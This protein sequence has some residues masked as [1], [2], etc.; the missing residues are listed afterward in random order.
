M[1]S[2]TKKALG[3]SLIVL[4]ILVIAWYMELYAYFTLASLQNNR[5]YLEEAVKKNYMQAVALFIL[6]CVAVISLGM[7][8]VPPLTMVGGFLFGF[9]PAGIYVSI[10][11]T[12][13]TTISFLLIRYVLGNV[14][15]GKYAQ[16]LDRF[17]E[18]IAV[19]GAASYLLTMQLIGLIPYFIINILAALAHVSTFTF[20]WTTFVGSLPILFIY[21]FAGRQLALVESVGDIFSPS[22]IALL[23]VLV[24]VALIPIVLRFSRRVTDLE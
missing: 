11:A 2:G 4:I 1:N 8:G 23:V 9:I 18:K 16:K 20:I 19:H 7:P 13:G 24:L 5:V 10:S 15:R 6:V 17:N 14:I 3:I 22:I 12:I 21:A